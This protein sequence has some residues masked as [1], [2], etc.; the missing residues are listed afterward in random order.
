MKKFSK[1]TLIAAVVCLV[2]GMSV[3]AVAAMAGGVG[4]VRQRIAGDLR[5]NGVFDRDDDLDDIFDRD[6][7]LD[8][9]FDRDLDDIFDRDDNLDDIFDDDLYEGR[10]AVSHHTEEDHHSET[11]HNGG[12][13]IQNPSQNSASDPVP[14]QGTKENGQYAVTGQLE[15]EV[16]AGRLEIVEGETGDNIQVQLSSDD[17]QVRSELEGNERKLTFL[18]AKSGTVSLPDDVR[19][20]LTLPRGYTFDKVSLEAGAGTITADSISA[21]Q[22][23]LDAGAGSV[24]IAGGK[25]Q[26]LEADCSFGQIEFLGQVDSGIEADCELGTIDL[27]LGGRKEDFNYKLEAELGIIRIQDEEFTK[28]PQKALT[29]GGAGK[30]A[31]LECEQGRITVDFIDG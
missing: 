28:T 3:T 27:H 31:D 17:I 1:I 25:V 2:L 29:N 19:A 4:S 23:E 5:R 12:N 14:S 7:D 18:P 11:Y 13:V 21:R 24:K 10:G 15:I 26:R 22:L 30:T 9:R 6:D 8:D 20:V 16:E